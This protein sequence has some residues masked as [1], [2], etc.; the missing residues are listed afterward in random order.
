MKIDP[1]N[2]KERWLN[3][4][5]KNKTRIPEISK[6]NS[7]L[8]L[9]Y[10]NDMEKGIN[11]SRVNKK[12]GRSYIRIN[13]LKTRRVFLAKK[14]EQRYNLNQITN[15]KEEQLLNFFADMRNGE[16]KTKDGKTYG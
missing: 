13:S 15:L 4:K 7:N 12:G 2:H 6:E 8:I 1:H 5:A 9:Q 14:F 16:I 11:I 10:L 3:W